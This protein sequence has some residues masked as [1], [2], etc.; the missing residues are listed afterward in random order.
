MDGCE[1]REVAQMEFGRLGLKDDTDIARRRVVWA[2]INVLFYSRHMFVWPTF[3]QKLVDVIDGLEA[4]WGFF[5]GVP[6]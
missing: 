4:G 5:D 2:L 3:S 1:P 6:E